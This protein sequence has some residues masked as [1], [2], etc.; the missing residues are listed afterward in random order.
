MAKKFI[1]A[2]LA[3]SICTS[4]LAA[5]SYAYSSDYVRMNDNVSFSMTNASYWI[6]KSQGDTMFGSGSETVLRLPD[7]IERINKKNPMVESAGDTEL[8]MYEAEGTIDG[9]FLRAIFSEIRIPGS[10]ENCYMGGKPTT[11]AYWEKLKNN[12]DM[13]NVPDSIPV[14]Y[15]Y[16]TA[17]SSLRLFPSYDFIGE[18]KDDRFYDVNVMSE[19]MPFRPLLILHES[20]DKQW[21]YVMFEGY[22]GWVDKK[23]VAECPDREDWLDR[24]A[25]EDFLVVTGREIRLQDDVRSPSLSGQLI[26]MGTKLPLVK[27]SDAP[28]MIND[29][30]TTGCY[31]V[32]LPVRKPDGMITDKYS[33]ISIKEDVHVGYLE[34]TSENVLRLAF[35]RLGDRYGWAGLYHSND[36]SGITGEIFRCFGFSLPRVSSQIAAYKGVDTKDLSDMTDEQKLG[37]LASAEPGSI[38][39]FKGHIMIYLGMDNGDPYC[40]SATGTYLKDG[41][42]EDSAVD[43]NSVI[44]TNMSKTYRSNGDSWLTNLSAVI[45]L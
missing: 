22:S 32:K 36:C 39:F 17:R 29:R 28:R 20:K 42:D 35:K 30:E 21:Y 23:Y 12:A 16:S 27:L 8:S 11:A 6:E 7:E 24:M 13:D 31:I 25:P 40:I 26:P 15:G 43:T 41:S 18:D 3:L 44:I 14:R 45:T 19:Y 5:Q 34:Y 37:V 33:L 9:S 38:L 1:S 10:P 2:L 4:M